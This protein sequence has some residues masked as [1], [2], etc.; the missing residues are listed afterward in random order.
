MANPISKTAYYTL[1]VRA[2]DASRPKPVCGDTFAQHFMNEEARAIWEKFKE[3]S[4]PNISNASRHAIID[5]YLRDVLQSTPEATVVMVGAGFDTRAFRI[6]GGQWIEIDEPA[7]INYK[8]SALPSAG[9]QNSLKRIAIDFSRESIREKLRPFKTEKNVHVII[10]GVL[11]YLDNKDRKDLMLSLQDIFPHHTVYCD[12]MRKSFFDRYSGEVHE[13]IR[14]LGTTFTELSEY[15]E[16]L[17]L[18]NGYKTLSSQSI[19]LYAAQYG[20]IDIPFF[21]VKYFLKTLR[22]G[23]QIWRFEYSRS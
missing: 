4:R 5:N 1:G 22:N 20:G 9:A 12:L 8:E 13:K 21:V 6:K 7:I 19:P 11:M 23:Y 2:W 10:E 17:L 16:G 15:P 3:Y 18:D 14:S